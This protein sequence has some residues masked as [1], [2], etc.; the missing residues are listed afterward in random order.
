MQVCVRMRAL[1]APAFAQRRRTH[2]ITAEGAPCRVGIEHE[3]IPHGRLE[4]AHKVR[5]L[6]IHGLASSRAAPRPLV[7][8]VDGLT[9]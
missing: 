5:L 6:L 2:V 7:G 8:T 9:I 3:W 1:T 4:V